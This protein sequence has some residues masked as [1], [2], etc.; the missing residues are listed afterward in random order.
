[1]MLKE[2]MRMQ[3]AA[4][5]VP[6]K[7]CGALFDLSYDLAQSAQSEKLAIDEVIRALRTLRMGK[8]GVLCWECRDL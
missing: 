7:R 5:A 6:C 1:M 3:T 8:L 2:I 4:M